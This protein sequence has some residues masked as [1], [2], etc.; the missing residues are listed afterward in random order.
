VALVSVVA[1]DAQ[2][3]EAGLDPGAFSISRSGNLAGPLEVS[4]AVGGTAT[5]GEDY[6]ALPSSAVIPAGQP[7][8]ELAVTPLA[9]QVVEGGETVVLTLLD[10]AAYDLGVP[11]SATVTISDVLLPS[12]AVVASD[13][14]AAEKAT[15]TGAF[16]VSRTG[17]VVDALQVSLAVGGTATAGADYQ[18]LPGT[19]TI[20]AGQASV[21]LLVTPVD[22]AEVEGTETVTLTVTAGAGYTV[23]VPSTATV[24]IADNDPPVVT[25][26]ATDPSASEAGDPGSF[27]ITRTGATTFGLLLPFASTGTA[28]SGVDYLSLGSPVVIPVGQSSVTLTVTPIAD[29]LVEGSETVTL[30][31]IFDLT[32]TWEVGSPSQ[33][34]VTIEDAPPP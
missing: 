18:P 11:A 31:L 1:I 27:T 22:D 13:A 5:A 10:G 24:S 28:Q 17:P 21:A 12:V 9:D 7:S 3:A 14:Q 16:T 25:V 33:A 26:V 20:P 8:V 19:V 29:Q 30:Q 4:F 34:T 6:L 15:A 23:G 32:G 2:A